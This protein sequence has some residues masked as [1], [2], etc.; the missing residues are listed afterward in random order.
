M[1]LAA[2]AA[3]GR[4]CSQPSFFSILLKNITLPPSVSILNPLLSN[5]SSLHSSRCSWVSRIFS[6]QNLHSR[7]LAHDL[8]QL[9]FTPLIALPLQS[10]DSFRVTQQMGRDYN[11]RDATTVK[12]TRLQLKGTWPSRSHTRTTRSQWLRVTFRPSRCR[13]L[14]QKSQAKIVAFCRTS[15]Q[16]IWLE[17]NDWL[18]WFNTCSY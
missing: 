16:E 8:L 4:F 14:L 1:N 7:L 5:D 6:V 3:L 9:A 2:T 10:R 15:A 12:G 11:E 18:V 17:I 13:L